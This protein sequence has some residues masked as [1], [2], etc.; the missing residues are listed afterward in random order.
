MVHYI[1]VTENL[2]IYYLGIIRSKIV[3]LSVCNILYFT[4]ASSGVR[5]IND[6]HFSS[7]LVVQIFQIIVICDETDKISLSRVHYVC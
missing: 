7:R 6:P 5:D 4:I 3:R 2:N 1:S